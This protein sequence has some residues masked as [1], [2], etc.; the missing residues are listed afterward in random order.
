MKSLGK[1]ANIFGLDILDFNITNITIPDS[2]VE[3]LAR[4]AVSER[5]A[6]A[7]AIKAKGE[8]ES[9][10][11][12]TM[13]AEIMEK[14]KNSMHVQYLNFLKD[15]TKKMDGNSDVMLLPDAMM[16]VNRLK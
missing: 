11:F 2:L 8:F 6:Q 5:L 10:K 7:K 16:R 12:Q 14:N 3:P 1:R 15:I 9:S 4:E 13:T